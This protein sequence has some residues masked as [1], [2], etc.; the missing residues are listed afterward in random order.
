[1]LHGHNA[2][3]KIEALFKAAAQALQTAVRRSAQHAEV[4]STKGTL[5]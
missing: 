4:A 3:H 2:H 5:S 1:V